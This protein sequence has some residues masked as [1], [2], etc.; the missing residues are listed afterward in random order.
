MSGTLGDRRSDATLVAAAI[1]GDRHAFAGIYDRYA[2]RMHDFCWS[3]LRSPD[4]AADAMQDTFVIAAGRLHQLRNP[5]KLRPWLYAVARSVAM[6]QL[7]NRKRERAE[8]DLDEMVDVSDGP[9]EAAHRG[10]LRD[11][12]WEAARGLSD[13]DRMVMDLHLRQ[14]LEGRDLAVAMDVSENNANVMLSRVRDRVERSLGAFLVARLGSEHCE[15]LQALLRNWDGRFTPLVRKRV[16]RHVDACETCD[17]RRK[18]VA[19]PWALLGTV[20][21]LPAP[22]ALRDQVLGRIELTSAGR[23]RT[24]SRRLPAKVAAVAVAALVGAGGIVAG[25]EA[26]RGRA[27]GDGVPAVAAAAASSE[28]TTTLRLDSATEAAGGLRLSP[29]V[30]LLAAGDAGA[31]TVRNTGTVAFAWTA[32]ATGSWLALDRSEGV[33][34]AG[35][36]TRVGVSAGP[37]ARAG[38]TATVTIAYEGGTVTSDVEVGA[39]APGSTAPEVTG[40]EPGGSDNDTVTPDGATSAPPLRDPVPPSEPPA[41]GPD[42]APTRDPQPPADD[43]VDEDPPDDQEGRDPQPEPDPQ[44]DRDPPRRVPAPVDRVPGSG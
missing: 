26:L 22:A 34:A 23:V 27:A 6:G 37:A 15:E 42:D 14:G 1:A 43:P 21:L 44:L 39:A 13:R 11:L 3:L 41:G 7:R 9:Y 38:A 20:P 32:T 33:V 12:V 25:A 2:D 17:A 24:R 16:A 19:S 28:A 30:L 29:D 4:E 36:L 5:A 18:S 10:E 40:P 8:A 31:L 35:A